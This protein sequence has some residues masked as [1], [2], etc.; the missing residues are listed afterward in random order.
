MG[1]SVDLSL[2]EEALDQIRPFLLGD[3]G[4]LKLHGVG[5]DGVVKVELLGACGTCPLSIVTMAAGIEQLV[6]Q[7]VPNVAGVIALSPNLPEV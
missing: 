5:E 4:D 2:L 6:M 1:N 3:G 7:R